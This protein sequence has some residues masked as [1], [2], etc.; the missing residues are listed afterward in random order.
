[1]A[2]E[3]AAEL[4]AQ[5]AK[6]NEYPSDKDS[7]SSSSSSSKSK[8]KEDKPEKVVEPVVVTAS[9]PKAEQA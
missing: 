3:Q 5:A 4:A 8:D 1:L 6:D 9:E 7:S 2:D